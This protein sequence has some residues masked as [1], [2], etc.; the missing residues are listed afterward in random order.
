MMCIKES[1][2]WTWHDRAPC[3]QWA[4][5]THILKQR[6]QDHARLEEQVFLPLA[7]EIL[8]RNDNHMAALGLSFQMRH[9]PHVVAHI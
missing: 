2:D 7:H 8:G 4:T 3:L 5:H 6:Y 1:S 9:L